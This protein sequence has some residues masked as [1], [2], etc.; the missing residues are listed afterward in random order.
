MIKAYLID[1]LKTEIND[2]KIYFENSFEKDKFLCEYVIFKKCSGSSSIPYTFNEQKDKL[3]NLLN[4]NWESY[5]FFL[6]DMLLIEKNVDSKEKVSISAIEEFL[7]NNP[8][9]HQKVKE[10]EKFIIVI[11]G[12]WAQNP[13]SSNPSNPFLEDLLYICKPLKKEEPQSIHK[14]FCNNIINCSK[15]DVDENGMC[16]FNNCL[17]NILLTLHE[18]KSE[19]A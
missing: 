13:K 10:K 16:D 18:R 9:K 8:E 7:K 5:D 3:I 6:V 19:L 15:K 17:R 14:S 11:T 2:L 1:D 12:H 4:D